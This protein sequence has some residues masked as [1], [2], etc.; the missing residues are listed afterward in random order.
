MDQA[1]LVHAEIDEGA[2]LRDVA[3]CAFERHADDQVLDVFDAV[4]KARH[5]EVRARVATG[6]FEFGQHI[7]HRDRAECLVGE[8]LR[9]QRTD[10]VAPA[11]HLG[12]RLVGGREHALDQRVGFGVHARRVE[13]VVAAANA[14]KARALLESLRT[15]PAHVEQLFSAA[16][17][18]VRIAPAHDAR[19]D[20]VAQAGN[21]RQQ[22]RRRG[23]QVDADRI[24]AVLDHRAEALRELAL[25]QVVLVLADTD[26]FR[27]DLDELGERVL[28][29][30]RDAHRTAQAHVEL[31]QL[32]ARVLA[33]RVHRRAGLADDNFF[34]LGLGRRLLDALDQIAGELVGFAAAGAVADRDQVHRVCRAE[35]AERVQRTFPVLARLERVDGVCGEHLAGRIDHGDLAAGANAGVEPHHDSRA[36][37]RGE[38]Q[39]AQVLG[40]HP[41]RDRFGVFAQAR[42]QVALEAQ[43][44]LDLPGPRDRLADQVIGGALRVAPLQ[45]N[46]DVAFGQRRCPGHDL[47]TGDQL[48][49]Q[50]LQCAAAKDSQGTV[51]RHGA[52]RLGVVEVIAEFG[53]IGVRAVL[54][55]QQLAPEQRLAPQPVAQLAHEAGVFGPAFGEDVANAVEDRVR[56]SETALGI[57]ERGGFVERHQA[58]VGE[59]LVRQ[60]LDARFARDHGLRAALL[61][62]G[63]VQVFE[64]LLGRRG[65][66]RTKQCR[67]QLALLVD[68]LQHRCTTFF[69]FTQVREARFEFAQLD[70]VEVVGRFLAV[71]GDE[72]HRGTTIEQPHGCAH[73]RRPNLQFGGDLQKNLVQGEGRARARS[74]QRIEAAQCATGTA[75]SRL[76]KLNART[77][78]MQ[79][80]QARSSRTR[81]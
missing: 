6:F 33:G 42:E 26:A 63:Q 73:L 58:R 78:P 7:G 79:P 70:V 46:G 24:H 3:D 20:R 2:K 22:R 67:R 10:H 39:V 81:G 45:V 65:L 55:V 38:Q 23:V 75:H 31:G 1:V 50:Q 21:A 28:Q 15:E 37:R 8:R 4:G 48:R 11:H 16:E 14:Q 53:D 64:F 13:R 19:G 32:F 44:E 36:G 47:F 61:L 56:I 9:P 35:Q 68:A 18:A 17:R 29:A 62:V 77:R 74:R 30:P 71:A 49:V 66:E 72:R 41:D 57:D 34:D 59:Q 69:E 25:V 12:R 52:D 60:R 76:P 40:E 51:R 54:A 80:V 5:L 43:T 27:V